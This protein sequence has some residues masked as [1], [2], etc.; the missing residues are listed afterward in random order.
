MFSICLHYWLVLSAVNLVQSSLS[1]FLYLDLKV[2]VQKPG[3]FYCWTL[4]LLNNRPPL[5][6]ILYFI[7]L[8]VLLAHQLLFTSHQSSYLLL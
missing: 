2:V 6:A 5:I 3:S 4:S 7:H 8:A 1:C